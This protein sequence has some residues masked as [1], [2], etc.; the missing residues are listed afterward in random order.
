VEDVLARIIA[1]K[2]TKL[3]DSKRR[4]PEAALQEQLKYAGE[5]RPF[6]E[7]LS[8]KEVAI[9]AEVK[10][11]SPSRGSLGLRTPVET[12]AGH[13]QRGGASAISVLT[14]EDYFMGSVTDLQSVRAAVQLPILRKDFIV[15]HYQLYE[16]RV[17]GAD[18]VLLIAGL[19]DEE[20]LRR[21]LGI[22]RELG[23]ATLVETHSQ[24]D[25]ASAIRAGAEII[26][27][28]N[29]DL[30]T[31]KTDI[32]HTIS[33]AGLVPDGVLLVSESGIFTADDVK[34]L[35]EA[36]ADAV[37]VGESLVRSADPAQKIRELLGG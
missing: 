4:M 28:N 7:A 34:R 36:G 6:K 24:E 17:I 13:Y 5:I 29:R 12:L 2:M 16:S 30:N 21:Y 23:L 25:L 1:G 15:D 35:S 31:F 26:G 9:I 27:V 10:R 18:A 22:C 20:T 8:G 3:A 37:L 19:L 32:S 14:E 11:A 33:L